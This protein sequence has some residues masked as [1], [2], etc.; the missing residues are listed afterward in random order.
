M[1][2]L[3][4]NLL[5]ETEENHDAAKANDTAFRLYNTLARS[6]ILGSENQKFKRP[7]L[8]IEL[9]RTILR[10]AGCRL[11]DSPLADAEGNTFDIS[12]HNSSVQRTI[13]FYTEALQRT[14]HLW[15]VQ[16]HT[17]SGNQGWVGNA[18]QGCWSWF[19]LAIYSSARGATRLTGFPS[20]KIGED[21][22][23]IESSD[24][25]EALKWLSHQNTKYKQG[26]FSY[27]GRVF[28]PEDVLW[29]YVAPGDRI[30]VLGCCQF[31]AWDC[32]GKDGYLQTWRFY[33]PE[34]HPPAHENASPSAILG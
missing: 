10:L 16:L 31:G 11:E 34:R 28:G 25:G 17:F 22:Y 13:W 6:L 24:D 15:G 12:S 2:S 4:S 8:P 14:N 32:K 33:D 23:E 5:E 20:L 29:S 21:T 19:E 1:G 27:S 30:V 26:M 7:A 3:A 18:S 9:V